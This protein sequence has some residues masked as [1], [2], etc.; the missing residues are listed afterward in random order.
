M[1]GVLIQDPV[2]QVQVRPS[3]R[4]GGALTD[5]VRAC[6]EREAE[7]IKS[8][9]DDPATRDPVPG[10]QRHYRRLQPSARTPN[11]RSRLATSR[12]GPLTSSSGQRSR[13]VRCS[14]KITPIG[15]SS[16]T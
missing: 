15:G 1:H 3:E 12:A 8:E 2:L 4:L 9:L 11:Q 7:Q 5:R 14:V 16:A 6:R 13:W 10:G